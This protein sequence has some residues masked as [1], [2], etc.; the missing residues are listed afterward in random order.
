[1]GWQPAGSGNGVL[2][3]AT[4]TAAAAVG[5]MVLRPDTSPRVRLPDPWGARFDRFSD[6]DNVSGKLQFFDP[7]ELREE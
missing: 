3:R 1:M 4:K 5:R 6:N 2:K 7:G